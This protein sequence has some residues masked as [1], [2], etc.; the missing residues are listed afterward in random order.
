MSALASQPRRDR[1]SPVSSGSGTWFQG[2][3]DERALTGAANNESLGLKPRKALDTVFGLMAN[4]ATTTP[5][6]WYFIAGS[7]IPETERMLHLVDELQIG[8]HPGGGVEPELDR[9]PR[10]PGPPGAGR[11][12]RH[13]RWLLPCPIVIRQA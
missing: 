5:D 4:E 8:R 7:E 2:G 13:P 3:Q 12:L 10:T 9:G 6:P 11:R 1:R